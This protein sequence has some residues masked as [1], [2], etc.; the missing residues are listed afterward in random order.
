MGLRPTQGDENR[1]RRCLTEDKRL[2]ARLSR[3]Q[4]E[5]VLSLECCSLLPLLS[6][7]LGRGLAS[8][9]TVPLDGQQAGLSESGGKPP[10]SRALRAFSCSV[11]SGRSWDLRSARRAPSFISLLDWSRVLA[12]EREGDPF[13]RCSVVLP[14][15]CWP[16]F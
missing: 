1:D 10:H 15:C 6:R 8:Q 7:E 12:V 4:S 13:G 11:A 2:N 16:A 9:G 14:L 5:D 3:E